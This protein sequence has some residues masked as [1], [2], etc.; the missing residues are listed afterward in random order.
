M[1]ILQLFGYFI[2]RLTNYDKS[3]QLNA[4]KPMLSK[5]CVQ[6]SRYDIVKNLNFLSSN[7]FKLTNIG[8]PKKS[9]NTHIG[10]FLV[11]FFPLRFKM[12]SKLISL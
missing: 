10:A 6:S 8:P 11:R 4:L 2:V 12:L 9:K 7:I 1:H 3:I 5:K